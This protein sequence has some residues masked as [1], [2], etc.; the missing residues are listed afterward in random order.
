MPSWWQLLIPLIVAIL[1]VVVTAL[2][3]IRLRFATSRDEAE[4][5]LKTLG[6]RIIFYALV[7]VVVGYLVHDAV[8]SSAPLTRWA[9]FN[10]STEVAALFSVFIMDTTFGAI[11][12]MMDRINHNMDVQ[13]EHWKQTRDLVNAHVAHVEQTTKLA[14]MV[15]R[16]TDQPK[17]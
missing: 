2:I 17:E 9:V 11:Y 14:T 16:V 7:L 3:N 10:I 1:S 5:D 4:A 8:L 15:S 12:T 6:R 13:I